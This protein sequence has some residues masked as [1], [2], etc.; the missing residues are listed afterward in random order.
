MHWSNR[1][2]ILYLSVCIGLMVPVPLRSGTAETRWR[3]VQG[4]TL[5]GSLMV[6]SVPWLNQQG[7][8]LLALVYM[9]LAGANAWALSAGLRG[10]SRLIAWLE[11][12]DDPGSSETEP[13]P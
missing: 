7:D 12:L 10:V 4:M 6:S 2:A 13:P 1:L 5:P 3:T 11:R 9:T 8:A